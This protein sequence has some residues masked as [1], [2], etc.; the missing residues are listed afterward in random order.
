MLESN[1][2]TEA[3]NTLR[4]KL[5]DMFHF[6]H[7]DLDFGIFRILKIKRDEV[8]QFIDEKLPSIVDEALVEVAD[9]LYY[10]QLTKVKEFV[11]EEGSRRQ[12]EWLENIAE[13]TQ[14]LIDF[15]QTEDKEELIA[16][17]ETNLDELKS[18]LAFRVYNHVHSFFEGYYRDGDFG[19][20]D[21]STTSY[22]VDYPDE[23]DYNGAD[24]LFHWKCRDSYYVK[25]ATG[26]NSV[27]FEVEGKRIEY[28]LEGKT[29]SN[30]AQ[31]NNRDD[32][33]HY[34]F[35][36]IDPPKPDDPEQT[37][38]VI[39]H[40]AET[41]TP[42]VEIY[43]EMNA[44]IF[45][46][47]DD[48]DIYFHESLKRGTELGKPIFKDLANTYDKV[49]D[50]RLQGIKALHINLES[51]AEKLASHLDFKALGKN[52]TERQ[53]ALEK[54]PRV[55][56][57]HTFDKNLNTFFVGMDSD[58][59]IHKDLDRFLKTEQRRYIQNTILGDLET[60]LNPSP[61]N[62][63]FAI[64]TAFRNVTDEVIALLVAVETFQKQLFLMK[65]KVVSTGYL[66]SVGK[67]LEVTKDNT[68]EREA[69]ISQILENEAQLADWRDTFGIDIT[70]QLP[71][72]EGLYPTLPLDTQHFD[73]TFVD[74]LLALFDDLESQVDGV[75]LNSENFQALDLLMEKYRGTIRCVHIDPPYNT[76]TSGFLYKNNYQH[77][78][79]LTMMEN[80]LSLAEQLMAPDS[81]IL[82]HIDENEYENLF[83]VFNTLPMQ[84]Q[85]TIVW[86]KRNPVGGTNTIATQHEYIVCNSKGN[87]KLYVQPLNREAILKKSS[88]LIE[89]YGGVT[90]ECR[91]EFRK[92]IGTNI[93]LSGGER[94][95]S[96]IDDEGEV[97]TSVHMG[98]P[99]RRTDP[100]FFQRLIH[101]VTR[102]LCP[103]PR[104]G[105][106][107]TPE[108]MQDLLTKN[109]IL[110]GPD[111]TTQP[112][113]KWYL[114]ER[115]VTELSSLIPSGEKGK[116][117][118]DALGLDFPYCHPVGLYDKLVWSVTSESKGTIL[119]FF[120]GS[121]TTGHA[122]LNLNKIDKEKGQ[123]KFI[124]VEMGEY[125]D[126]TLK[127]RIRRVMF[128]QNWKAGK[129]DV[130]KKI[131]GT[132]GIVKYQRLEQYEDVLNNLMTSPPDYDAQTELPVKYLYRPEEQQ[133]R[134][135]MD[136]RSPFSNRIT[137]GKDST[138]G[139]VDVLETYCYLK[140]LPVQRRLRFDF[141][142]QIYR[143]I[144]SGKRAVVFRNVTEVDDTPQ[145][146]EILADERLAGVT[147]LDVNCNANQN[148]LVEGSELRQVNRITTSDFDT[149]TVWDTVEA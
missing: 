108:F 24:I 2:T 56:R 15:L 92:W 26:F 116:H 33:K 122:V 149:G 16:P 113:R 4:E 138:E 129:P 44:Q 119:D 137:Y 55:A 147:Q 123:R 146:L 39:L 103:V 128:S 25:T 29:S 60:L 77:S 5:R 41:S 27:A 65:K 78:S 64:A 11:A 37:W 94:A 95:Y 136:M 54:R 67:I 61:E 10:S 35:D 127:E 142:D 9:A 141:G 23:A 18:K 101:P 43:S 90:Q 134:L 85:G 109:E 34:R 89:K 40:L 45:S 120:A 36:R 104:N 97:Y 115:L 32:F 102:K 110:F 86:D 14:P 59:F 88:S 73:E 107:G 51:Y 1:P 12:R 132:V 42:K 8:N 124:L 75:L 98:A 106:S 117:Q 143:V 126:S 58:Y 99:E 131:D 46:E 76:N 87:I 111:E 82:C 83:H 133:I 80:R 66:I 57:F 50:G 53:A 148:T 6:S 118:M 17:L 52:K 125:F 121:G 93:D 69:I 84:N 63:A 31:N 48:V 81:C 71:L 114:K 100:K 91:K 74:K 140:G 139:T 49:N 19:Y 38:R 3:L 70:E 135:V 145:L 7:N 144:Q 68:T 47:T 96:E 62:P 30:I 22:K 20:N 21:R 105:F 13:H 72:L 79:W 112:R 130:N 28:R